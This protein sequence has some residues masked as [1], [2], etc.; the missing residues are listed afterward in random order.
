MR[1]RI[2]RFV[3]ITSSFIMADT[4]YVPDDQPTIQE[5]INISTDG[6]SILVSPG[7]YPES[8]DF[9][10]KA[11]LISSLYL[12]EDDSLLVGATIIDAQENGSVV[13]FSSGETTQSIIQGFTLQNGTG[14]DEDPD[15]N[16]SYYTYGGGIYCQ[17]S[18]PVI[19]D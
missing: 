11:I 8:I 10:G 15:D 19:R 5:A 13:T 14:N 17:G 16:G 12:L 3:I 7:F 4:I 9:D 6:D 1:N 2:Y 18:D